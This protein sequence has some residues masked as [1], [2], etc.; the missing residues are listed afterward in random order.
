MLGLR[1]YFGQGS[2]LSNDRS[3]ASLEDYNP[4]YGTQPDMTTA[5][6]DNPP[7]AVPL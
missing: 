6:G 7:I 4:W 5:N 1:Y 3:G 2:L